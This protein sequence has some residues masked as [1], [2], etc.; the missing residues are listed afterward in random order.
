MITASSQP[1]ALVVGAGGG[2]GIAMVKQ[3][4]QQNYQV[5]AVSRNPLELEDKRIMQIQGAENESAIDLV[6]EQLKDYQG[7]IERVVVCIGVLHQT[8]PL[9][10]FPEKRLEELDAEALMH[11]LSVNTVLPALWAAKL[12]PILKGKS[13]CVY[14]T[15]SARVGS[16]GD[17]GL[18]GWYSYR[19]S[20]AALNMLLKT[21]SIEYARRAPRVKLMAFHPGTTDTPLSQPFQQ[22]VPEEK[23]FSTAFVAERLYQL[24][25]GQTAD[26]KLSYLDWQGETIEW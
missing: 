20:K 19:A 18:G 1:I 5:L 23:L 8:S 15:L 26:G 6:I 14:A 24:M 22:N 9:A 2:I 16:I 17:N 13:G 12:L 11:T 7:R 10:L 4:L 3:F 21:A 25:Q